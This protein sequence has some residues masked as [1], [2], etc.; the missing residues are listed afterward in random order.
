VSSSAKLYFPLAAVFILALLWPGCAGTGLVTEKY[1]E[2]FYRIPKLLPDDTILTN[3]R[4]VVYSDNQ[5]GWRVY[6]KFL[7]KANW[8][9]PKMFLFPFYQ[10]YLIGNGLIGLDNWIRHV[11]DYGVDQR[12]MVRDALYAEVKRS[13]AAFI[14]NVGDV[15]AHD[16]RRPLHWEI[17]L[18]E[19]RIESP[20]LDEI[21]FLPVIGNHEHAN[22][23]TFGF[24]NYQAV[25]EYPRFYVIEFVDAALFVLDSNFLVD[26]KEYIPDDEQDELFKKWFVSGPGDPP[27][28]LEEQLSAYDKPFKLVAIHHPMI[29]CAMHTHDWS[30]PV[31]GRNLEKKR[32]ELIDL[33][34]KRGVQ[35]VMSGHDHLYQH[36]ILNHPSGENIHFLVGGGGGAPTRRVKSE[37]TRENCRQY[38]ESVGLDV[39]FYR[40]ERIH[41]YYLIDINQRELT[42]EVI[43]VT[44]DDDDPTRPVEK[45]IISNRKHG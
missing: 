16:G 27:S 8:V 44:G 22:D 26:Q 23:K 13:D 19:N 33:L 38:Y 30:K 12:R 6:D 37:S 40:H 35:L 7:R 45:I 11:P 31:N 41:H 20:L 4:F 15:S 14:M 18:R 9:T 39:D 28:W 5:T 25:F 3:Q 21:P 43:E 34:Q 17:F 32:G 10:L 1:D 24:P 42:V 29:T 36:N 2:E